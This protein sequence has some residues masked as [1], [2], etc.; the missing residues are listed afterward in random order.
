M[1]R[2]IHCRVLP[3]VSFERNVC[4]PLTLAP[5]ALGY[6]YSSVSLT[7]LRPSNARAV[8]AAACFLGGLHDLCV[9]AYERCRDSISV[10]TIDEWLRFVET[11]PPPPEEGGPTDVPTSVF[12]PYAARL[13]AD[14]FQFLVITLP[15]NL[16]AFPASEGTNTSNDHPSGLDSLLHIYAQVPF[17]IFKHAV[18]APELPIGTERWCTV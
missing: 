8:L 2:I 17:D 1:L 12:G 13:R 18:E 6:L 10:E 7:L 5:P 9:Q 4:A 11:I 16:Q 14:V 3:L 15:Q